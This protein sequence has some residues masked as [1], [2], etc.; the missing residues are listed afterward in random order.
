MAEA[1]AVILLD[2]RKRAE[3]GDV[4]RRR[5]ANYYHKDR[6]KGLYEALYAELETSPPQPQQV[7]LS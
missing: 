4:M 7:H 5:A 6:V 2:D 1:L 3:M